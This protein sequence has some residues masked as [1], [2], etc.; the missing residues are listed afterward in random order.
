MIATAVV[1]SL[2]KAR[3]RAGTNT[4]GGMIAI[5]IAL[6]SRR[7]IT[8][9]GAPL[10]ND[11]EAEVSSHDGVLVR[12]LRSREREFRISYGLSIGMSIIGV[13]MLAFCL[14]SLLETPFRVLSR[15]LA[16]LQREQG[17]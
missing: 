1:V 7:G 9:N 8:M 3:I 4:T 14:P 10:V 12:S 11:A 5:K 16:E 17:E 13:I 6:E 15:H 2:R